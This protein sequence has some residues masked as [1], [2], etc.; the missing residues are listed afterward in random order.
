MLKR[1]ILGLRHEIELFCYHNRQALVIEVLWD[2]YS[3][4]QSTLTYEQ[5]KAELIK[6][7]DKAAV[8]RGD[9]R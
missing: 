7:I 8:K 2:C 4:R 3:K 5:R 6:L 1:M 9:L